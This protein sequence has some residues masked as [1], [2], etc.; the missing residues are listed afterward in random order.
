MKPTFW[1][2]SHKKFNPYKHVLLHSFLSNIKEI[3]FPYYDK[4]FSFTCLGSE[5][6]NIIK[7]LNGRSN[8][9]KDSI[10]N[11]VRNNNVIVDVL[12]NG[13][14]YFNIIKDEFDEIKFHKLEGQPILTLFGKSFCWI[15]SSSETYGNH[16]LVRLNDK[17]LFK[18]SLPIYIKK[19][20]DPLKMGL[21]SIGDVTN[22]LVPSFQL[23]RINEGH[24][25]NE[26]ASI[27]V[28]S[29]K[30]ESI[31]FYLFVS[32]DIGWNGQL[33]K[34]DIEIFEFY[35][36][37]RYLRFEKFKYHLRVAIL[38]GLNIGFGKIN[39]N[40]QLEIT[41]LPEIKDINSSLTELNEGTKNFNEIIL[42][43][44]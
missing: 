21:L 43:Y 27:D 26:M 16:R 20:F 17:E 5:Q 37:L 3:I 30:I 12:L 42:P 25:I 33:I 41:G 36:L 4:K 23:E 7:I 18:I 44:K 11:F 39:I 31:A 13:S 38:E 22:F 9:L 24:S 10:T 14:V 1:R 32:K 35:Y 40:S 29:F 8:N 28:D 6:N 34:N 2:K 15:H 19:I